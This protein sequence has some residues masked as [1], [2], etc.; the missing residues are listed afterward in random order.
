[1]TKT[2]RNVINCEI[3]VRGGFICF[4][5]EYFRMGL[6]VGEG[7]ISRRQ[8]KDRAPSQGCTATP[9]LFARTRWQLANF[10]TN[11]I[12]GLVRL[13]PPLMCT[14]IQVPRVKVVVGSVK[15]PDKK[16]KTF[17]YIKSAAEICYGNGENEE[18][19]QI[20]SCLGK[21]KIQM[22]AAS[23]ANVARMNKSVTF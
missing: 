18:S 7:A 12:G 8:D 23:N 21:I 9:N 14:P 2:K 22:S 15:C 3:H 16:S 4:L 20:M 1:M 10:V 19:A 6:T 11:Q 13:N 5:G 17:S